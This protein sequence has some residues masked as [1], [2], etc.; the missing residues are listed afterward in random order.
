M[1]ADELAEAVLKILQEHINSQEVIQQIVYDLATELP[2]TN[3]LV[4]DL[5]NQLTFIAE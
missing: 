1:D 2:A 4:D 3:V 5:I